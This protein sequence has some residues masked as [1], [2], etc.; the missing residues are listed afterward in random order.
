MN[1]K[2]SL[3]ASGEVSVNPYLLVWKVNNLEVLYS[4]K[5]GHM[6]GILNVEFTNNNKYLITL[7]LV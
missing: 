3:V 5:T 1:S 7:D 2:H 6:Q 4:I